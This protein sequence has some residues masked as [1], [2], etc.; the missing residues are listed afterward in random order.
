MNGTTE[1][2]S[3]FDVLFPVGLAG[4]CIVLAWFVWQ[5]AF[6]DLIKWIKRRLY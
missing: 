2:L 1:Y 6:G 3:L 5:L 4:T